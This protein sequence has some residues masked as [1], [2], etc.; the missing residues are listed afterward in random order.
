MEAF[1]WDLFIKYLLETVE[2]IFRLN[3]LL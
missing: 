2:F 1:C 3:L